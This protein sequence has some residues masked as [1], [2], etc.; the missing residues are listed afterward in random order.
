M[1]LF[2]LCR[3]ARLGKSKTKSSDMS[4]PQHII[5]IKSQM[6]Q[7]PK[8][9]R[10]QLLDPQHNKMILIISKKDHSLKPQKINM[11]IEL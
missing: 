11:L 6:S 9:S 1:I 7:L 2:I 4:T 10:I 5:V 3:T 8:S